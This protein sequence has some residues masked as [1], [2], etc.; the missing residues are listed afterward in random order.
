MVDSVL[1][2]DGVASP[3]QIDGRALAGLRTACGRAG[4]G[5]STMINST[6]TA[7]M[8]ARMAMVRVVM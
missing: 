2:L 5:Q 3:V 4:P 1:G 7:M 6:I 8:R